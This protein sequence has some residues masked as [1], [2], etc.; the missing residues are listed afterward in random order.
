MLPLEQSSLAM[1]E[2]RLFKKVSDVLIDFVAIVGHDAPEHEQHGVLLR[3]GE[4]NFH[5]V[6]DWRIDLHIDFRDA[7][8]AAHIES[9]RLWICRENT[10]TTITFF[11]DFMCLDLCQLNFDIFWLLRSYKEVVIG[12]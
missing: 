11:E 2:D 8:F 6:C 4:A 5:A 9:M 7:Y 10:D 12:I 3:C 1:V